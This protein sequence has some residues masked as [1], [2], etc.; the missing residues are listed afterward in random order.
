MK[1][2][3][4][5]ETFYS[6]SGK[7]SDIGRQLSL[8]GVA[9]IWLFK[10]EGNFHEQAI[11]KGLVFPG[12]LIILTLA[13][14]MLQYFGATIIWRSFY[15]A[16][17]RAHIDENEDIQHSPM[18]ELPIFIVFCLKVTLVFLAYFFIFIY[19]SQTLYLGWQGR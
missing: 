5:R 3:E 7:A 15:R 2:Q 12:I 4:Y 14:D 10:I 19:L 18:L 17:E 8:A 1:L 6:F 9:I 16:K 11:P 13:L